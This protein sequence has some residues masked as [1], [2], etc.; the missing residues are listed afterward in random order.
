M[1]TPRRLVAGVVAMILAF[2]SP[3]AVIADPGAAV[4][5][6]VTVHPLTVVLT[7]SPSQAA[8]GKR[9]QVE[10]SVLNRGPV[11]VSGI[12]VE[13]RAA[14]DGL[15]VRTALTQ[16]IGHLRPAQRAS[17]AWTVCGRV[18]GTY[19]LLARATVAG[20]AVESPARLLT[21]VSDRKGRCP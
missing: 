15:A 21:I 12:S 3:G 7:V 5:A 14:S 2:G 19:V 13:L 17:V 4:R 9:V 10:A 1:G 16:T 11:R 20:A 6:E 8:V 18:A